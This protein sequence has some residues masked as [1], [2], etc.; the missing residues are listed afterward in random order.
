MKVLLYYEPMIFAEAINETTSIGLI[1][2]HL[3]KWVGQSL[4][5]SKVEIKTVISE[6]AYYQNIKMQL[7]NDMNYVVLKDDEIQNIFQA[8]LSF[9]EIRLKIFHNQLANVEEKKYVNLL[10]SVVGD[11]IPDI[12]ISFPTH[13]NYL[14]K[15]FPKALIL[16]NENGIFSR[17]PFMRTLRFEPF[18]YIKNFTNIY[19]SEINNFYIDENLNRKIE[20]LKQKITEIIDNHNP[21]E[22]LLLSLRKQYKYLILLPIITDNNYKESYSNDEYVYLLDV[23]KKIPSNAALIITKHDFTTGKINKNNLSYLKQKYPN[24]I[25]INFSQYIKYGASSMYFYKYVDA[26]INCMTGTGLLATLWNTRIIANDKQYSHWFSDAIGLDNIEEKLNCK[27]KNKNGML[28]WYLTHYAVFEKN[29]N[30]PDWYYNYF[31]TKLEKYRQKG[32]TFDFYEQIEDFDE[33]SRYITDYVKNYYRHNC[34]K[35]CKLLKKICR[36]FISVKNCDG[37]KYLFLIGL[38]IKLRNL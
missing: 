7:I 30:K 12:V 4:V 11:F 5:N 8:G 22:K 25:D 27:I 24:I 34:S 32:I 21:F 29:F 37:K 20:S 19:S 17:P 26:I 6:P 18:N 1:Y 2:S 10:K 31:K 9:N 13:N 36:F 3:W 33:L 16:S 23:V 38:K 35:K 15:A 28:Y 14:N